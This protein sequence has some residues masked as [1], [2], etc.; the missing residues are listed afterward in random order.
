MTATA[1]V[2]LALRRIGVTRITDLEKDMTVEAI[3][4]RDI[5]D[6]RRRWLLS[7]GNWKFAKK[8]VELDVLDDEP[9][10]GRMHAF[11][12]PEDYIRMVNFSPNEDDEA[13]YPYKIE[14][15]EGHD[16]VI[17]SDTA[18]GFLLY[19]F[20]QQD[21]SLFSPAF[22]NVLAYACAMDLAKALNRS[23][24]DYNLSERGLRTELARAKSLDGL[25]DFPTQLQ[26]GSWHDV[27]EQDDWTRY[28]WMT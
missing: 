9:A 6:K 3:A 22:E 14:F 24:D 15:M 27:R 10:F 20:D 17:M 2:N 23:A 16:R 1:I 11:E 26:K 13:V 21:T 18:T 25:E 7:T 12:L 8:R 28:D 4:A 19:I 5:Y